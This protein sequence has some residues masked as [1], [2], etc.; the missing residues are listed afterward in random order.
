MLENGLGLKQDFQAAMR[1]YKLPA[2][3]K[4]PAAYFSI[5]SMYEQH[6]GVEQDDIEA[7]RWYELAAAQ[8][9]EEAH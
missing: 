6:H 7:I 5:G 2:E 3:K 8:G 1:C 9:H 4:N